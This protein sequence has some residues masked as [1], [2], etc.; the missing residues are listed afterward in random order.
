M[1][2]WKCLSSWKC[3]FWSCRSWQRVLNQ[4]GVREDCFHERRVFMRAHES[5][6]VRVCAQSLCPWTRMIIK[7]FCMEVCSCRCVFNQNGFLEVCTKYVNMYAIEKYN[8][9]VHEII[10]MEMCRHLRSPVGTCKKCFELCKTTHQRHPL[11]RGLSEPLCSAPLCVT[12][13]RG[14]LVY[15]YIAKSSQLHSKIKPFT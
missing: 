10:F 8:L 7:V 5:M 12:L 1:S 2:S 11:P 9:C 4:I 14:A 3:I 15:F 13:L 6:P